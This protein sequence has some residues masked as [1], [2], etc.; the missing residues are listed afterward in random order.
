MNLEV[1]FKRF[2]C[3][4]YSNY[5]NFSCTNNPPSISGYTGVTGGVLTSPNLINVCVGIPTS[6]MIIGSDTNPLDSLGFITNITGAL[7]GATY[8]IRGRN[9]DTLIVN[10]I[11]TVASIGFSAFSITSRDNAC[12]IL[13]QTTNGFEIIV[14]RCKD[15]CR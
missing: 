14:S 12:P 5:R 1:V 2:C 8:T 13:G 10:W 11:P 9:P 6:F 3:K 4:G 7:P 15:K